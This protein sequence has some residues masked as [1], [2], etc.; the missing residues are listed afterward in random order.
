MAGVTNRR[1]QRIDRLYRLV[2]GRPPEAT[3]WRWACV[4][5][6]RRP[7]PVEAGDARLSPWEQYAQVLLLAN[8][9]VFVD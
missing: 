9:F 6:R 8:E 7:T 4:S 5:W 2:Y 1:S 3:K